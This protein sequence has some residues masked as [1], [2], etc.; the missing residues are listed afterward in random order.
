MNK[1]IIVEGREIAQ[2]FR[3]LA[4]PAEGPGS[5][6]STHMV[7][8]NRPNCSCRR[9]NALFLPPGTPSTHMAH[10][11]AYKKMHAYKIK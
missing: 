10:I 8:L 6:P 7:A 4:A 9:S 3:A 1:N 5:T 2:Y 11:Y